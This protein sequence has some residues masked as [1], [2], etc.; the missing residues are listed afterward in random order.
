MKLNGNLI[1]NALGLSEI[2]NAVIERVSALPTPVLLSEA[3]RIVFNLTDKLYYYNNGTVWRPIATGTGL[4]ATQTEVNA[5]ETTLGAAI[6]NDGTFN[7]ATAFSATNYLQSATSFTNALTVLDASIT[8]H[9]TLAEQDDVTLTNAATGQ[10]LVYN[11]TTSDWENKSSVLTDLFDVT[12][13]SPANK[14]VVYYDNATTQWV[15][16]TLVLSDVS[17]ITATAAQVNYLNNADLTAADIQKLADLSVTAQ[18]L[19]NLEGATFNAADLQKLANITATAV[20]LN[21]V[22]GVTSPIQTQLDNKQP[23]DADLTTLAGFTPNADSSETLTINGAA[24]THAGQNDIIVATGGAEG[25]RWTLKREAAAR[26]SLGLGNIAVMDEAH[27]IRSS[28]ATTNIA[29]DISFNNYKIVN[30]APATAGTD[31]VNL[32]QLQAAQAGLDWKVE[33]DVATTANIT[34]SGLQ[35]ID[36][37]SATAGMIVLVKNQT[38][39]SENGLYTVASGAWV[40]TADTATADAINHATTFVKTGDT[41]AITQWTISNTITTLDTDPVTWVQT[42]ALAGVTAGIGLA[43]TGNTLNINLGAG[44]VELPSD[45]VGIDLYD[46]TTSALILTGTGT[47]RSTLT[48]AKLHLL[49]DLTGNG[50]LVQSAAGLKVT[51]NTITEAELTAS[52]AGN[53]LVGGNGTALA[54]A[55][56]SGTASTGGDTPASWAGVGAVTITADAVGVTLGGTST[57]A[58]PGNHVHKAGVITFDNTNTSLAGTPAT[59]QAAIEAID[60]TLDDV[61][62]DLTNVKT[63]A[64]INATTGAFTQHTAATL[65]SVNNATS[66]FAVDEAL[67]TE[68]TNLSTRLSNTFFVYTSTGAALSHTVPHATGQKYCNV[69]VVDN[70]TGSATLDQVVIPNSITFNSTTQL[71]VTFNTAIDCVVIVHGV[72]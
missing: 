28:G 71:T 7:G 14:Q 64:G 65:P 29:S 27:F 59:V 57:T 50:Q 41:Q 46:A 9:N 10:F 2:Q 68:I 52:V 44:I 13:T 32:N 16:Q 15:N 31:A 22:D 39:A 18:T 66:L 37:V 38:T 55:S 30:L 69:T 54:V 67:S 42:N 53:G 26:T 35:T 11:A 20:E 72:A 56:A 1:L 36:G 12:L 63:A 58:A 17:D 45:E 19:N 60:T 40:R 43:K 48:N 33:A 49:L 51:T 70:T 47:D 6:A 62:A 61:Y 34:L 21:Y 23:L 5:I 3:G 4:D 25:S 8:G 24:I